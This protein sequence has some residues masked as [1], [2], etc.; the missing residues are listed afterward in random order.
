MSVLCKS[1]LHMV[2]DGREVWT[3]NPSIGRGSTESRNGV[4]LE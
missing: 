1:S 2:D 3:F 4:R